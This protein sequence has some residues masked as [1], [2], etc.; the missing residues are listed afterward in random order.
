MTRSDEIAALE[1]QVWAVVMRM[2][3]RGLGDSVAQA[4]GYS[5]PP[6]SWTLLEYLGR[7]G[8]LRVGEIAAY[9]GVDISSVTPRLQALEADRFIERGSDPADRRVSLISIG[10]AGREALARMHKARR[11]LFASALAGIGD[12]DLGVASRVLEVL[13]ERL[14]VR[15]K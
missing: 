3:H 7:N 12:A 15:A 6:A 13:A 5:L 1:Q 2:S 8:P 9:N 11:D 4:A 10:T 14:E